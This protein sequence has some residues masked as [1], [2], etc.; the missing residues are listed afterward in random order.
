[1]FRSSLWI[2]AVIAVFAVIS[3]SN[4]NNPA[5]SE[6]ILKFT[7]KLDNSITIEKNG[8]S[9]LIVQPRSSIEYKYTDSTFIV[10]DWVT[11]FD[12]SSQGNPVGDYM[13]GSF[14]TIKKP[15]GRYEFE[16]DNIIGNDSNAEW[17]FEPVI[18]NNTKYGLMFDVNVGLIDE[19]RCY[20]VV[21]PKT[22]G[23]IGYYR[24]YNNT[25]VLAFKEDSNYT[26]TPYTWAYGDSSQFTA[27]NLE[28]GSGRLVL[29]TDTVNIIKYDN[30]NSNSSY[31]I[32]EKPQSGS[33]PALQDNKYNG[34]RAGKKIE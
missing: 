27:K 12:S 25:K 28:K 2:F 17:F 3:C 4:S 24:F 9:L 34:L 7:N 19:N 18:I 32:K 23:T 6:K 31:L 20:C 11:A 1:M 10:I 8:K 21:A 16:I 22:Q 15:A 33:S 14:D 13:S 26:G 5:N 30:N 29:A